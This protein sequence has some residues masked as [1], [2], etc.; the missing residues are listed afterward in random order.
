MVIFVSSYKSGTCPP[1]WGLV[2][3][4]PGG[5]RLV[6]LVPYR[7]LSYEQI[8]E[9]WQISGRKLENIGSFAGRLEG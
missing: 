8:P 4:L 3:D 1:I 2:L 9:V 6:L 5:P 7:W